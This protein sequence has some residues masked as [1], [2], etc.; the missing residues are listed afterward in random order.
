MMAAFTLLPLASRT[1]LLLNAAEVPGVYFDKAFFVVCNPAHAISSYFTRWWRTQQHVHHYRQKPPLEDWRKWR[2]NGRFEEHL[3][4][5]RLA[6]PYW[7]K[8]ITGTAQTG[9]ALYL[10]FEQLVHEQQCPLLL[11]QLATRTIRL[12]RSIPNNWPAGGEAVDYEFAVRPKHK[13]L[14]LSIIHELLYAFYGK[15]RI[16]T[17]LLTAYKVEIEA[18]CSSKKTC[19]KCVFLQPYR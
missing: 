1:G 12:R 4:A 5:W 17:Q 3:A 14:L 8:G 9:I 2:D 13:Y 16:A 15:D 19:S 18:I 6:W 10:P 11:Q 7:H